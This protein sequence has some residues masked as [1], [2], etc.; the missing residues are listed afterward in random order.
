M[1]KNLVIYILDSS[2]RGDG[3]HL[4]ITDRRIRRGFRERGLP[5][6]FINPS[7]ETARIEDEF[8]FNRNSRYLPLRGGKSFILDAIA[9]IT[10]DLEEEK[11][12]RAT[13]FIP[14]LLQFTEIDLRYLLRLKDVVELSI[15]G[16]TMHSVESLKDP[17]GIKHFKFQE[18]FESDDAFKILWADAEVQ[19]QISRSYSLRKWPQYEEGI[20]AKKSEKNVTLGFFGMLSPER[21]LGEVL[22]LALFNPK[23]SVVI[24]GYSYRRFFIWKPTRFSYLRYTNWREKRLL[25]LSF[26]LISLLM[27]V[28]KYL[29]NVS[30]SDEPFPTEEDLLEAISE[31]AAIFY[32][33]KLINGSGIAM[34]SLACG[35]PV[36]WNGKFGSAVDSLH[37]SFPQGKFQN[38]EL[39]I[40]NR[41]TKKVH[42]IIGS[43]PQNPH[44]WSKFLEEVSVLK[45]L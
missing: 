10:K 15:A 9:W 11:L 41:L 26:G 8:D 42:S 23:L 35:I 28:L 14:W 27:S 24:R 1:V 22:L 37:K 34:K 36:L 21:G 3:G 39:F 43:K 16:I 2:S 32:Y 5:Y 6:V 25:S 31:S 38:V 20:S 40:P 18:L 33:A 19:E 17:S 12:Q 7:A 4:W 13:I 30:F 44:V 45:D 29:P